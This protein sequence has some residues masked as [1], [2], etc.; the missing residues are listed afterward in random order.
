V[1][2]DE[3]PTAFDPDIE[4]VTVGLAGA[5]RDVL[6]FTIF[7]CSPLPRGSVGVMAK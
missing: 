1:T 5:E 3:T 7:D 2:T 6:P 4:A